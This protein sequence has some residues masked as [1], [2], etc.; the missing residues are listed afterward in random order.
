MVD[1][2]ACSDSSAVVLLAAL[3]WNARRSRSQASTIP[4]NTRPGIPRQKKAMTWTKRFAG[5]EA[6]CTEALEIASPGPARI[7][8]TS[9]QSARSVSRSAHQRAETIGEL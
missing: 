3:R 1:H 5:I 2:F 6:I 7:G 9:K 8:G 4:R